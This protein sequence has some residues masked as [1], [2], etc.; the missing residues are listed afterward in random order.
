MKTLTLATVAAIAA[1]SAVA[2]PE[3]TAFD[4]SR[5]FKMESDSNAIIL[6]DQEEFGTAMDERNQPGDLISTYVYDES[7]GEMRRPNLYWR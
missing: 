4:Q 3:N 1:T 2:L 7:T 5:E 6:Q